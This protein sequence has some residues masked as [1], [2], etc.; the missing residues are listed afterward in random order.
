MGQSSVGSFS[1]GH[2]SGHQFRVSFLCF[3]SSTKLLPLFNIEILFQVKLGRK[4]YK[5]FCAGVEGRCRLGFDVKRR[6]QTREANPS[7]LKNLL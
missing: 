3:F 4:K 2:F 5:L 6:G 7:L 1:R